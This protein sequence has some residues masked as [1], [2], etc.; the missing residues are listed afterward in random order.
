MEEIWRPIPGYERYELSNLGRVRSK[1]G[2][3]K[4]FTNPNG[5]AHVVI[6][7]GGKLHTLKIHR[8]VARVFVPGE[9]PGLDVCHI[10]GDKLNNAAT[11]L[12]WG[13]RS[14]NILDQV[15]MGRHINARKTHCKSGHEFSPENTRLTSDG[16]RKCRTCRRAL[17]RAENDRLKAQR[18]RVRMSVEASS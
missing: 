9:A 6:H 8:L 4:L 13:T 18:A 11:N 12:R 3:R 1:R 15:R 5:Y 14:E 2:I 10:D 17:K 16:R 7:G